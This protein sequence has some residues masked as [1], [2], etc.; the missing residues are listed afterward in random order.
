MLQ[1][2][3]RVIRQVDDPTITVQVFRDGDA[4]CALIGPDFQAGV[5]GFGDTA[6]EALRDLASQNF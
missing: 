6:A 2:M 5:G 3:R 1:R 4:I